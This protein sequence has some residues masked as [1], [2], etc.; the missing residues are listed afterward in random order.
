MSTATTDGARVAYQYRAVWLSQLFEVLLEV[1]LL[2]RDIDS[3]ELA[4]GPN[5][6]KEDLRR[7][8]RRVRA[9]WLQHLPA[10]LTSIEIRH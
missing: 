10:V 8:V 9:N 5:L 7:R 2:E 6:G 4:I 3:R 1:E